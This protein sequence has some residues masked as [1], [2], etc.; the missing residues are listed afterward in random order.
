MEF[1][2]GADLLLLK[3]ATEVSSATPTPELAYPRRRLHVSS[4]NNSFL[5]SLSSHS[6]LA[7]F[8]LSASDG[9]DWYDV[10]LVDGYNL[11]MR[12]TK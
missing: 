1:G 10:S 3:V 8:T 5:N 2:F 9:N 12:I 11:P 6:T 7:E 4:S